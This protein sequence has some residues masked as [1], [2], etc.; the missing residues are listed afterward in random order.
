[1]RITSS[2]ILCAAASLVIARHARAQ[3]PDSVRDTARVAPVIVTA[4]GAPLSRERV[5]ASVTVLDG[6]TLRA[7]GLTQLADA[8]REVPGMAV[9][10]SGSYGAQ[11][12]LFT[13]GGQNNYTKILI[14]GV[15]VNDPGGSLDLAFL[16]LDDVDRIEI[17]RGP[18]SVLYG[19]DA[20]SGVV[21]IFTKR[22]ASALHGSVDA[23][24]GTY[25]SYDADAS[26]R[27]PAGP[28]QFSV[29]AAHHASQG[30]Y[31][32]NSRYR[33]DIGSATLT[34]TPW[35]GAELRA[36]GRYDDGLAHF[37]TD[38][39]GAPVDPNAYRTEKRTLLDAELRQRAADATVTLG[40]SS[41]LADASSIDPPNGPGDVGSSLVTHTLRQ[42][43]DLRVA[44]PVPSAV[45]LTVG[46]T[47]ERQHELSPDADRHNGAGYIEL[48]RSAGLTT[49]ALGARLD[50][51]STYGDFGTYRFTVSRI[52][53]A[54]FRVR[55][56]LGTAFRE[57]S[58]TES[59]DTPF[60]VANPS[61]RPERT[62]S[63]EAGLEHDLADGAV[64]LGATYFHQR[65]VDL[66][67]YFYDAVTPS[68]SVYE[69]IARAR[70]AG[71]EAEARTAPVHG[72][73]AEANYTWLDT[74]VLQSGFDPSPEAT[75]VQGG[76]LLRRPKHSGSVGLR[77]AVPRGLSIMAQ[78]SYVGSRDDRLFH[79]AP[80]YNTDAVTLH[81]YTK[82]DLSVVA[83][84]AALWRGLAPVDLT[85][86]VDNAF[87]A[88]YESVA[89]YATPG[90]TLSV[91]ARVSF[92]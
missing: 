79:G 78:A 66:I 34:T 83:P 9:V 72:I 37:P 3:R 65:F 20:V 45:T 84:L 77:Y 16:T 29:D 2:L 25:G 68:L 80:T 4:T 23:R 35:R 56:T 36:T 13:R 39:T 21:Q 17:L 74:K 27:G 6:A 28:L 71:V 86:R 61:L 8:L 53:P 82:L 91:G 41:N 11:T 50:H 62:T 33:N 92:E 64:T 5:P 88:H 70:A 7:Q 42:A 24:G 30:I 47:M 81:P 63:W 69:N 18:A 43:A 44:V 22:G 58:F 38:F 85:A 52:L 51:S 12:S 90:R 89:G 67:D 19:S 55:G 48:L 40:L 15:P 10:Q 75:L 60:S 46:G 49:A 59:F 54:G 31:Q 57:P 1:M 26:A 76:P 32:F 14:D 73:S 87:G